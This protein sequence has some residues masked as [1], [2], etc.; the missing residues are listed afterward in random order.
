VVPESLAAVQ[1]Q[2]VLAAALCLAIAATAAA[3]G[4]P[5][6]STGRNDPPLPTFQTAAGPTPAEDLDPTEVE[7]IEIREQYG[8]RADVDWIR[9]VAKDPAALVPEE[10]GIP[11]MPA[12][13]GDL[14]S[15]R[16]PNTL[17]VQLRA[18][19]AQF[20]DDFAMAYINEKASGAIV[21]FKTNVGR[22]RAALALLP[23]DGPVVVEEA[24]WSLKELNVFLA[25]VK[26]EQQWIESTGA[27]SVEPVVYELENRVVIRYEGPAGLEPAIER[28]FGSPPWLE[29][30]WE[31]FGR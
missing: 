17:I 8:L 10:Y 29:A 31:G 14:L 13:L 2:Y 3:C 18:Y 15:R 19:G 25:E 9:R 4:G 22:H 27:T 24:D 6:P 1:R 21:K 7:S 26:A 28:H 12:E 20:P 30:R 23:L 5:A 16:W 11:L